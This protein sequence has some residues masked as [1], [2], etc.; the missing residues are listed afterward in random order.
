MS[1]IAFSPNANGNGVFTISSPNSGTNRAIALPDAAGTIPLLAAASNTAIT[2]TPA[3]LNIL[4]GVTSTAAELNILDGVTSTTAELNI[5][6][7]VTATAAEINLIDGGTARGTTAV[8]DGDGFLTND[9]GTMRMTKVETLATYM[10]TKVGGGA[11]VFIASS[12]VVSDVAA[13]AFTNVFDSSKFDYYVFTMLSVTPA[14]DGPDL[15]CQTSTDGGSNFET[16]NGRYAHGGNND[17]T[18][19]IVSSQAGSSSNEDGVFGDFQIFEVET[20]NKFTRSLSLT[21]NIQN[22]SSQD[23]FAQMSNSNAA[24]S[25]VTAEDN[26]AV[27]FLWTAGNVE[28]GEIVMYGIANA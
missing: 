9:G 4:D 19:L 23:H 12:G 21:F 2:S 25:R 24:S 5:L 17:A 26:N 10:G 8:A 15:I 1:K 7:G 16:T 14:N 20:S 3:E 6:D 11:R 22:N 18:G 28:S 13:I 27:R